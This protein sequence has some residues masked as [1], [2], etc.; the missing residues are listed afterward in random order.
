MVTEP[1]LARINE[2]G[3]APEQYDFSRVDRLLDKA[4]PTIGSGVLLVQSSFS[5][6]MPV[7]LELKKEIRRVVPPGETK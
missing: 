3:V 5:K 2:S 6:V 4:V 1:S 7:Y